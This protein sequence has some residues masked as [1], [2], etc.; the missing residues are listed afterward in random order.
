MAAMGDL[1]TDDAGSVEQRRADV[2]EF[3]GRMRGQQFGLGRVSGEGRHDLRDG[4]PRAADGGKTSANFG[5][6]GARRRSVDSL[7]MRAA[8]GNRRGAQG[9]AGTK[10]QLKIRR[11]RRPCD[12]A[13][14]SDP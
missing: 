7:S 6:A 8:C 12:D 3:E 1:R 10:L 14:D 4:N 13:N 2:G 5:V 9:R 11:R